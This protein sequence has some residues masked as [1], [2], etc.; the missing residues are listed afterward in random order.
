VISA[1]RTAASAVLA[2]S[3][4][5]SG[6]HHVGTFGIVGTGLIAR[7]ILRFLIGTQWEIETVEVFDVDPSRAERFAASARAMQPNIDVRIASEMPTLLKTSDLVL[8]A[9]VASR[10]HVHDPQ[11][12]AHRPVVLHISLRDLAPAVLVDAFNIVDDVDEVMREDT[13]LH[14]TE[15]LT[16]TRDF[17]AGSLAAVIAGR[18]GVDRARPVVFSPFGLGV[19]DLAVGKWVYDRARAAGQLATIEHFFSDAEL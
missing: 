14:L 13:S 18:C 19:L 15:Q 17:V 4:L 5:R 1:A 7:Y 2:A 8:F 3:H 12:L 9:T 6:D 16:G 11:L 10:P